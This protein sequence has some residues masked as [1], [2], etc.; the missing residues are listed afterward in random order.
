MRS[1]NRRIEIE[2]LKERHPGLRFRSSGRG[3]RCGSL[4]GTEDSGM[5][6]QWSLLEI[7]FQGCRKGW[8]QADISLEVPC[9]KTRREGSAREAAGHRALQE[10]GT[11]EAAGAP[12]AW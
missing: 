7:G 6:H 2:F 9:Y 11:G 4:K 3:H 8:S 10:L 1:N 5:L 12:G